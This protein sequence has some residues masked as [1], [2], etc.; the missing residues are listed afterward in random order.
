VSG[1]FKDDKPDGTTVHVPVLF[2]P[3]G[4]SAP[5]KSAQSKA[6]KRKARVK[7]RVGAGGRKDRGDD[8]EPD[9]SGGGPQ[10]GVANYYHVSSPTFACTFP[11]LLFLAML[12]MCMCA[13]ARVSVCRG[14]SIVSDG[15]QA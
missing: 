5:L 3:A 13:R 4:T 11:C 9:D 14:G 6:A 7:A 15:V 12:L 1:V 10:A 8:D 2:V